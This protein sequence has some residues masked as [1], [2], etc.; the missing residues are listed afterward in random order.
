MRKRI[1]I[2]DTIMSTRNGSPYYRKGDTGTV[3]RTYYWSYCKKHRVFVDF[4][5]NK[6]VYGDG[7]WNIKLDNCKRVGSLRRTIPIYYYPK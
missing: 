6:K 1:E 7:R 3:I 2:G 5:S 4:S